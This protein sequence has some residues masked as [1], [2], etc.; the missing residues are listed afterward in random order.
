LVRT[1]R[2]A[3]LIRMIGRRLA[4]GL[5]SELDRATIEPKR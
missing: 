3:D 1:A 4:A 2:N 5:A